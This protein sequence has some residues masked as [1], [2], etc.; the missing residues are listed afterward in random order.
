MEPKSNYLKMLHDNIHIAQKQGPA[1]N[2]PFCP[3]KPKETMVMEAHVHRH[4]HERLPKRYSEHHHHEHSHDHSHYGQ[5]D[6]YKV[7]QL[8]AQAVD[9]ARF[10][11]VDAERLRTTLIQFTA[12][13]CLLSE[14]Q[15]Q[16]AKELEQ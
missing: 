14:T 7:Q 12:H 5:G 15:G 4:E 13:R 11:D 6:S 2:C 10:V 16:L 1:P 8:R 9:Y 3:P